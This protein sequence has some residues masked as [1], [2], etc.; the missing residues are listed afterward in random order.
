MEEKFDVF[1]CL[2]EENLDLVLDRPL[3]DAVYI[4][5]RSRCFEV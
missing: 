4:E 2:D 3:R 1:D 5:D